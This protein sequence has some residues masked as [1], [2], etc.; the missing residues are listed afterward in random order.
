MQRPTATMARQRQLFVGV[1]GVVVLTGLVAIAADAISGGSNQPKEQAGTTA[2]PSNDTTTSSSAAPPSAAP[3]PDGTL[4]PVAGVGRPYSS[5]VR[6]SL[7]FRG[8]PT[9]TYYGS[10]PAPKQPKVRW[11]YPANGGMCS[12]SRAKGET[13]TWCGGGWT[14][15]PAV[16]ERGGRTWVV[17][18]AY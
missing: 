5:K 16:F 9:R 12:A 1:I 8:N 15:Q 18:G 17:F 6:G 2:R 14:G 10:G 3:K 13:K 11:F 4:S 7:T